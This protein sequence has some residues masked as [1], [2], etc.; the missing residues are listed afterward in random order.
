[1]LAIFHSSS[2]TGNPGGRR[3]EHGPGWA[4]SSGR[5]SARGRGRVF[6]AG[7]DGGIRQQDATTPADTHGVQQLWVQEHSSVPPYDR[8]WLNVVAV[9]EPAA[10]RM[11]IL[12][13]ISFGAPP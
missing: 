1:M 4:V 13:S 3:D 2:G 7:V 8:R 9:P 10:R 11:A 5:G 12:S 6:V